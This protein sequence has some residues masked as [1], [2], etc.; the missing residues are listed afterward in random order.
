[1]H[2][3]T[4]SFMIL[5][6]VVAYRIACRSGALVWRA[7]ARKRGARGAALRDAILHARG[8]W[9]RNEIPE[10]ASP[11]LGSGLGKLGQAGDP[12]IVAPRPGWLAGWLAGW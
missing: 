2:T 10:H 5:P 12:G 11:V 8:A 1:M 6:Y 9:R 3:S 7:H 4:A